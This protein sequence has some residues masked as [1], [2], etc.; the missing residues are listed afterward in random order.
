MISEDSDI[1]RAHPDYAIGV[2]NRARCYTRY[3]YMLDLTRKEVRDYIVD[4]VNSVLR[5]HNIEYVKWD[6]NRNVTEGFS[7]GRDADR[8]Q[9]FAHRYAL[10]VYD[11]CERIV[12]A[13]PNVF[14]E[15]C[16]GGGGRFDPA[17]LHYFPQIWTS[18]N[19]DA[20]SR[21]RIQYG[22]S[23]VYPLSAMSCHVSESPNHQEKRVTS[24]NT[25]ATIAHLGATGYE[26]DASKFTDGDRER[27]KAEVS[28]YN[29]VSDLVINGDLYRIDSPFDK[30]FFTVCVVSK[31]KTAAEMICY[32]KTGHISRQ[33]HKVKAAGLDEN[34]IYFV[35]ELK[36]NLSG[37][38]LMNAGW[39][40]SYPD[41]DYG[42]VKYHFTEVK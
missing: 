32:R 41:G 25:R 12:E 29:S 34:K 17:M 33:I 37:K 19:S 11:L 36:R 40:P 3:Q 4:S 20:E 26:L 39:Q 30:N 35:P 21:T 8:Q 9:E 31:D 42:A 22:T 10:G 13:N 2:P 15:G 24:N 14:F 27:V 16:S 28:E 7:F 5:T 23:I 18:D 1:F 38:T 6:H